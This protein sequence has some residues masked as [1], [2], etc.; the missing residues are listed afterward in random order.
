MTTYRSSVPEGSSFDPVGHI[1]RRAGVRLPSVTELRDHFG[2]GTDFSVVRPAVLEAAADRGTEVHR[3]VR[4]WLEGDLDWQSVHPS[5]V[6]KVENA[7]RELGRARAVPW[8]LEV[9][10]F[11]R[12]GYAGTPDFWGLLYDA[13]AIV[14]L[15]SGAA[16]R[17][18][19][20][21]TVGYKLG[22]VEAM[23]QQH[24]VKSLPREVLDPSRFTLEVSDRGAK[25]VPHTGA[26]DAEDFLAAVRTYHRQERERT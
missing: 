21:Q 10:I 22:K 19:W 11:S 7:V 13:P 4:F 8:D 9:P 14:D 25:F 23:I 20:F 12:R 2:F 18:S 15:K 6:R 16:V 24:A 1:Y 17:G 26:D 5:I 3:A